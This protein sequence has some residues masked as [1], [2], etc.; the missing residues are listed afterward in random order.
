M[1]KLKEYLLEISFIALL[2]KCLIFNLDIA[3]SLLLITLVLS[4]V[5]TKYFL[6][7]EKQTYSDEV[8]E[9]MK[10]INSKINSLSIKAGIFKK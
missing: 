8:K 5:Y 9:E 10:E 1:T 7:K 4:I 2:L 3:A 6:N